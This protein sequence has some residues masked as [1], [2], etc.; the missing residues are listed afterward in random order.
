MYNTKLSWHLFCGK[1]QSCSNEYLISSMITI[2]PAIVVATYNRPKALHRLLKSIAKADY[3]GYENIPLV[4]S[5]DGGGS[6]ECKQIAEEFVWEH[7]EKR[8]IAHAENMGLKAHILSCGDLTEQYGSIIMLEEDTYVSP[9]FYDYSVQTISYYYS[10]E[11]IAG[12]SLFF[13]KNNE[14]TH[15]PFTPLQNGA[16]VFF[17]Q[18]PSSWGQVWTDEQWRRFRIWLKEHDNKPV[19]RHLPEDVR[20]G[21]PDKSSWKKYYYSYIVENDLYFVIP[22]VAYSTNMGEKG[23]HFAEPTM[24]FQTD[25]MEYP[26]KLCLLPFNKSSVVY[27]AYF[28]LLPETFKAKGVLSDYQFTVDL[29][30]AKD[31]ETVETPFLLS[32]K[33]CKQPLETYNM[34]FSP[35]EV[36]VLENSIGGLIQFGKTEYF[37]QM[38]DETAYVQ[39][40]RIGNEMV[41]KETY[42]NA[43]KEGVQI[44]KQIVYKTNDYRIGHWFVHPLRILRNFWRKRFLC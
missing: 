31:L 15:T 5:I 9:Y 36:N 24:L 44:G 41:Y 12:V 18:V 34:C 7:G 43:Q 16:D 20:I 42:R 29:S 21:W 35:V 23:E 33:P 25:L 40:M 14:L 2:Y 13:F 39:L 30:G 22:Y 28:D 8:V 27:D 4:I 11:K 10:E 3:Q 26:T 17:A 37:Q 1:V 6:I 38:R 32:I 19:S